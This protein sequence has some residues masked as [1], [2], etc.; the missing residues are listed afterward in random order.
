M[1]VNVPEIQLGLRH[2]FEE[3]KDAEQGNR[4]DQSGSGRRKTISITGILN[5]VKKTLP[6]LL[7]DER[8]PIIQICKFVSL[9]HCKDVKSCDVAPLTYEGFIE[10]MVAVA[11]FK[12]RYRPRF[13]SEGV[14][15]VLLKVV[16]LIEKET[17][18]NVPDAEK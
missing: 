14:R 3:Y 10:V 12:A 7:Q 4:G 1:L 18:L 13:C 16:R 17:G 11:H 5:L 15:E 2:A 9:G 6:D 8:C